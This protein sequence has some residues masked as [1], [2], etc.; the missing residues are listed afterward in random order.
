MKHTPFP[1]AEPVGFAGP[2]PTSTSKLVEGIA[3]KLT[4]VE[5][6]PKAPAG[7][8]LRFPKAE[9]PT[10]FAG[11][12]ASEAKPGFAGPK[13]APKVSE[14][15]FERSYE[16]EEA[17]KAAHGSE[18]ERWRSLG[19]VELRQALIDAGIDMGQRVISD[20]KMLGPGA[21][22]RRDAIKLLTQRGITPPS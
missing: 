19:R 14:N 4:G 10:S 7:Q 12:A 8:P 6:P 11:P 1:K 5:E 17:R 21:M 13:E 20:A 3:N 18:Y 15:P 16:S 2:K 9:P 22:S